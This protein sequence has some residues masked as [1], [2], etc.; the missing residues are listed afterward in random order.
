MEKKE[1]SELD[2]TTK[3][4]TTLE[5]SKRKELALVVLQVNKLL[6]FELSGPQV[7]DWTSDIERLAPGADAEMLQFLFD[8][9][10]TER[11]IWDRNKGIQNIFTGLKF[12]GKN[13]SGYYLRK[14]VW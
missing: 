2:A 1:N 12:I 6:P 9:Y 13:E 4:Q 7:V 10:K 11:L 8:C 3:Q 14:R 5:I